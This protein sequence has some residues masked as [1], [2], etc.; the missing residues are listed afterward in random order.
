MK[1]AFL[2]VLLAACA[3]AAPPADPPD[4]PEVPDDGQAILRSPAAAV[5]LDPADDVVRVALE[6]A[7]HT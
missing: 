5:D 1:P 4:D 7:P 2:L 3:P 6:A